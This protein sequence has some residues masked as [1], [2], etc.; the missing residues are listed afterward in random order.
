MPLRTEKRLWRYL[1]N[2]LIMFV[3]IKT[4][5]LGVTWYLPPQSVAFSEKQSLGPEY[6]RYSMPAMLDDVN[7][8]AK[9]DKPMQSVQE[10]VLKGLYGNSNKGFAIIAYKRTPDKGEVIAIKQNFAGYTLESIGA[11]SVTLRR[12]GM[13]YAL[14]LEKKLPHYSSIVQPVAVPTRPGDVG[15]VNVNRKE[16]KR[17]AS[18]FD[19]IWKDIAINEIMKD[20]KIT[21]FRVNRINPESPFGLLGLRVGDVITKVNNKPMDSY[22]AAINIYKDIDNIDV[23]NLT[24]LRNNTEQEIFY[25]VH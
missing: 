24:I 13:S 3:I 20:G 10:L 17:Y 22:A 2:L 9:Q 4:I 16:V 12:G 7:G 14:S 15:S 11:E 6:A 1:I 5:A 21:G 19:A 18:D 25:E 8:P 23:L